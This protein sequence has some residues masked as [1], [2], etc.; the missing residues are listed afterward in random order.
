MT[1]PDFPDYGVPQAHAT[2]IQETGVPSSLNVLV[3][4]Q[5]NVA[6]TGGIFGPFVFDFPV[7]GGYE[8]Y[9]TP[10]GSGGGCFLADCLLEHLDANGFV[11][12]TETITAGNQVNGTTQNTNGGV[13]IRGNLHG[14]QLSIGGTAAST[15][16]MTTI[17]GYLS[18]AP[19]V[20]GFDMHCY[21][22]PFM[23][24]SQPRV[25]PIDSTPGLLGRDSAASL[26]AVN[27]AFTDCGPLLSYCGPATLHASAGSNQ[28]AGFQF[29][30]QLQGF[31]VNGGGTPKLLLFSP[32]V[33]GTNVETFS[34]LV[35]PAMLWRLRMLQLSTVN[36]P[37]FATVLS[38]ANW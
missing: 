9:L 28:G 34:D 35:L 32:C 19:A 16:T 22:V 36:V 23:Q 10:N 1:A 14:T 15:A 3:G 12:Q 18:G 33:D 26:G 6:P 29:A 27:G 4:T 20:G 7:G 37:G 13:I 21:A 17:L 8:L 11:T 30:A 25:G 2:A 31:T 24:E 5:T 38:K